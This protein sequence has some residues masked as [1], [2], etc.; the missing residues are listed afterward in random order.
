MY[1]SDRITLRK[2]TTTSDEIGQPN[3]TPVDIEVWADAS[4]VKRS[5][6]YSAYANGINVTAVFNVHVEDYNNETHVVS[7]SQEY[8]IERAYQKGEGT[9]ELICS[10]R[11]S[12][13]I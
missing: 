4:S 5:E 11:K 12:G 8:F 2:Y 3:K 6:Y 7:G 13:K 9:T 1:F 10:D